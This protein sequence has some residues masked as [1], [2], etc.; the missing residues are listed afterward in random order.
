VYM[1]RVSPVHG[2]VGRSRT[3]HLLRFQQTFA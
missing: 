1:I 3:I 2:P